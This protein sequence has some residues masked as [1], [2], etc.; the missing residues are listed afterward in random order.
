MPVRISILFFLCLTLK[1]ESQNSITGFKSLHKSI[2]QLTDSIDKNKHNFN[3]FILFKDS[4]AEKRLYSDT[5]YHRCLLELSHVN[6]SRYFW[7]YQNE[8]LLVLENEFNSKLN[9]SIYFCNDKPFIFKQGKLIKDLANLQDFPEIQ[10][11][12]HYGLNALAVLVSPFGN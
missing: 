7:Y 6:G 11:A 12:I 8:S 1:L 5:L 2:N 3:K 10:Q 9:Y 4:Q